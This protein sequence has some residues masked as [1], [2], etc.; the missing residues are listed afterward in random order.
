MSPIFEGL[1]EMERR[2]AEKRQK[3]L[4][5]Q[6]TY[7][8]E[9][10]IVIRRKGN[11]WPEWTEA[12]IADYK[13]LLF[14]ECAKRNCAPNVEIIQTLELRWI[15]R[16]GQY[17]DSPNLTFIEGEFAKHSL[18]KDFL[19]SYFDKSLHQR[20]RPVREEF[21]RNKAQDANYVAQITELRKLK[22]RNIF[23]DGQCQVRNGIRIKPQFQLHKSSLFCSESRARQDSNS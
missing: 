20:M 19:P 2:S 8:R 12:Q 1:S 21:E 3:H 13:A 23:D 18:F 6:A 22:R 15:S 10:A 11:N 17:L 14:E 9:Q 7:W 4:T 5:N 16:F